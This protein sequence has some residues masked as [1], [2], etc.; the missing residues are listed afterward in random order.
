MAKTKD[1]LKVLTP[2]PVD[3]HSPLLAEQNNEENQD[4]S[5]LEAQAEREQR[6]HDAGTTP[7]ADEP[8]TQKLLLTMASLWMSTFFAA[9]GV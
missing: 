6:E 9:L 1:G 4:E 3:E 2:Q 8:S 5:L 7:V